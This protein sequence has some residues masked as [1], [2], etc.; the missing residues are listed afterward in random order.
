MTVTYG[1]HVQFRC[2]FSQNFSAKDNIIQWKK[3]RFNDDDLVISING[4]VPKTFEKF[5]QTDLTNESSSLDLFQVN[6]QDSTTYTCQTFETQTI[7]C[8][9]NLVVLIKPEAPSLI[10]NEENIQEYQ[11]ITLTCSSLNGN[12]SPQYI[13][14]RNDTLIN[15]LNQ[16]VSMTDNSSIY[17][18]NVSRFD[19]QIKYECHISNQ[20]LSKPLRVEKYL[21]VK[22]RPYIKILAEPSLSSSSIDEKIIGIEYT[23]QKF[24]CQIDANPAATSVYWTINS[25]NIV[26]REINIYLPRLTSE[27]TGLYTCVVENSIGKINQ[28]IYLDV[29]YAPRVRAI[30]SRI[31]VN[32]SDSAILRCSVESNPLPYQIICSASIACNAY[33]HTLGRFHSWPVRYTIHTAIKLTVPNRQDLIKKFVSNRSAEEIDV[34]SGE[35]VQSCNTIEHTTQK[36][37]RSYH[38][39]KLP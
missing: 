20:A 19:N 9:Y 22:Y 6:R 8:Q 39:T 38:L 1:E 33:S 36:L 13:W 4:K 29:Q 34:F 27:Q 26:S 10:I 17:T 2:Q 30:E 37:F 24:T 5:Y 11:I 3:L 15:S 35:I 23:E 32:R 7:L 25:T 31:I 14:Y 16:Q 28:S 12:P 21:H 18:F